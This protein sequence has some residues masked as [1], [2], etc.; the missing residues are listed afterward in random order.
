MRS[1]RSAPRK[2]AP[3]VQICH[4]QTKP[5]ATPR[6]APQLTPMPL[7]TQLA[8]EWTFMVSE[9]PG[10][11]QRNR[12][13]ASS[14]ADSGFWRPSAR[15][16]RRRLGWFRDR[17]TFMEAK[18][19]QRTILVVGIHPP[20]SPAIGQNLPILCMQVDGQSEQETNVNADRA[21]ESD[22]HML[23]VGCPATNSRCAAAHQH[24][25]TLCM[26]IRTTRTHS[27]AHPRR[28]K[29]ARVHACTRALHHA[30][31]NMQHSSRVV[32]STTSVACSVCGCSE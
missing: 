30:V 32:A 6:R 15:E 25:A 5:A 10:M 9:V 14:S 22:R 11:G 18:T 13:G 21:A 16:K 19:M 29:L 20:A 31:V 4:R 8:L 17:G 27:H 3:F 1:P 24:T 28:H 23:E 12:T 7:P 2:P 26:S